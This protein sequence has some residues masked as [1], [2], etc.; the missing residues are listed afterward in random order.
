M[1]VVRTEWAINS[2]VSGWINYMLPPA[3]ASHHPF[4]LPFL[5]VSVTH[6]IEKIVQG[7]IH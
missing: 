6:T 3:T 7:I 4:L 1:Y 5:E 2:G